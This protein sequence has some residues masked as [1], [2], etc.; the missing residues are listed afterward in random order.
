M[1]EEN[2][3]STNEVSTTEQSEALRRSR[4][5]CERSEHKRERSERVSVRACERSE[6]KRV[7]VRPPAP[8]DRTKPYAFSSF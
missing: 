3:G 6:R 2:A 4:A 8:Q 1:N 5:T 7:R